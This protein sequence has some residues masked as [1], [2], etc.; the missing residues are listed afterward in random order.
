[1][2]ITHSLESAV[3]AAGFGFDAIPFNRSALPFEQNIY[4][5][6]LAIET[7]KLINPGIVVEG[8]IGE[9]GTGSEIHHS[10]GY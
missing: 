8:K 5:T 7:V 2:Q 9:F 3:E 1:M 4:E 10:D 6:Q